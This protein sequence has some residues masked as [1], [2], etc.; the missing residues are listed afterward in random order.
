MPQNCR[1]AY[2]YN[3]FDILG[4]TTNYFGSDDKAFLIKNASNQT[5][6]SFDKGGWY[7]TV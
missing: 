3:F 6:K 5:G 7:R 4:Q 2:T 1:N